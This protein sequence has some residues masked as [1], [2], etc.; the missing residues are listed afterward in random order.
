MDLIGKSVVVTATGAIQASGVLRV[1]AL[2]YQGPVSGLVEFRVGAGT[3]SSFATVS[4]GPGATPV[5]VSF[6]S[7]RWERTTGLHATFV[8]AGSHTLT[9]WYD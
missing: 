5:A 3:G 1:A 9:V 4:S 8:G 2:F 6:G 7:D